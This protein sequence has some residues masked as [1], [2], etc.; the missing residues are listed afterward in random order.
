MLFLCGF[1]LT[2]WQQCEVPENVKWMLMP[3]SPHASPAQFQAV[4]TSNCMNAKTCIHMNVPK[5]KNL[6]HTVMDLII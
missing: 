2:F 6:K 5:K 1:F 3:T 4:Q